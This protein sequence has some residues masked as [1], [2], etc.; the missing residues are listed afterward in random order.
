MATVAVFEVAIFLVIP[1]ITVDDIA[2]ARASKAEALIQ[3]I[4]V[5]MVVISTAVAVSRNDDARAVFASAAKPAA[6]VSAKFALV[7]LSVLDE[8]LSKAAIAS[9]AIVIL[10]EAKL[11][12]IASI[13]SEVV[14]GSVQVQSARVVSRLL[15]RRTPTP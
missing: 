8:K 1:V 13:I 2:G 7:E 5:M 14:Q 6:L 3:I 11:A 12:L 4:P 10:P 15:V 9:A